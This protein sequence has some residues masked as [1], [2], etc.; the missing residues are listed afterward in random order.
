MNSNDMLYN[1]YRTGTVLKPNILNYKLINVRVWTLL[2]KAKCK[3]YII[4]P[5]S[6]VHSTYTNFLFH[7]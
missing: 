2:A 5:V 4:K 6:F 3:G 1:S 7:K